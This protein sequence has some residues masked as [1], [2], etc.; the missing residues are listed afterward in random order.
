M[1]LNNYLQTAS[2][3]GASLSG[4][5]QFY[6]Q[7]VDNDLL[8]VYEGEFSQ[9][10]TRSVLTLTDKSFDMKKLEAGL[11]KKVV[12]VMIESLQNICKHQYTVSQSDDVN[13]I[14]AIFIVGMR[15]GNY[16]IITGNVVHNSSISIIT[17]KIDQ[18]NK[19]DRE[20]LKQL[21]KETR[22][23]SKLSEVGGA[24]LGF[25]DM[26]RK[27]GNPLVYRFDKKDETTSFYTLMVEVSSEKED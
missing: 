18:I 1:N 4:L 26:A 14:P 22:L 20:G 12:N 25:I 21:Y 6:Q 9:E 27:S 11:R 17:P 2:A 19:L 7:M 23:N 10:I 24:G 16:V 15:N 13:F 8:M 3:V 5:S